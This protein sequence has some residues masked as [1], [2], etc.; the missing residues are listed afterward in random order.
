GDGAIIVEG[1]EIDGGGALS[2]RD[3]AGIA[4]HRRAY[5]PGTYPIEVDVTAG[6]VLRDNIVTGFRVNG[7]GH[8][9]FGIVVEG[10][11][12]TVSGNV[13]T[14][15]DVPMQFQQANPDGVPPGDSNQDALSDWFSRGNA[16]RTCVIDLG[17]AIGGPVRV[18]PAGN[19]LLGSIR[20]QATGEWFCDFNAAI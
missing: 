1:N 5:N 10:A 6:V 17:N 14:D 15:S 4:V 2:L 19:P 3:R 16:L 8:E 11:G 12:T 7:T 18:V 9:G 20:N 13:V